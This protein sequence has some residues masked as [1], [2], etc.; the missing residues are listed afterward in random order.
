VAGPS[1][2]VPI[3][4]AVIGVVGAV[5]PAI[6]VNSLQSQPDPEV[7][8]SAS[9][10]SLKFAPNVRQFLIDIANA[11]NAPATNL[12]LLFKPVG[13][14]PEI[15]S[16]TNFFSTTDLILPKY[17][18]TILEPGSS[19]T[20]KDSFL[21]IEIPKLVHGEGS[22]VRL[23]TSV[24]NSKYLDFLV[25][26]VYDQG[27][28]SIFLKNGSF[29]AMSTEPSFNF[30][31]VTE[32]YSQ[33]LQNVTGTFFSP[34]LAIFYV[35]FFGILGSIVYLYI[36]RRKALRRFL[37]KVLT[38]I[39]KI[40]VT[41]RDEPKNKDIFSEVWFEM[42]EKM[43]QDN[44]HIGDYLLINDFYSILKRRNRQLS[45]GIDN[46]E[47]DHERVITLS[48]LNEALLEAAENVLNKVDWNKYR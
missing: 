15:F 13:A 30:T 32:E 26:A 44:H 19:K 7:T 21:N 39:V 3:I 24:N 42:P 1:A 31:K 2:T 17:N 33:Q 43:R 16:I 20:V 35:F 22:V 4:V 36:R 5:V 37:T 45:K 14:N 18:N 46:E 38:N 40:R 47:S 41:L 10:F 23:S 8:I 28:D 12:S 34:G 25:Y 6:Y 48:K 29:S 27:S 9:S 11:G